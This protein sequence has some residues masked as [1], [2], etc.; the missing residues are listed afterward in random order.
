L[1]PSDLVEER[2]AGATDAVDQRLQQGR[3]QQRR[4]GRSVVRFVKAG[5]R[6]G[7]RNFLVALRLYGS[8]YLC[9]LTLVAL[10]SSVEAIEKAARAEWFNTMPLH[11]P[12]RATVQ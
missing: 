4:F 1:S 6:A 10:Y 11:D 7:G 3:H 8:G 5:E 9:S 2:D 12:C